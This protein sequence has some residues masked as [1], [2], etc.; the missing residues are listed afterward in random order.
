MV[1]GGTYHD[2]DGFASVI[3]PVFRASGHEIERT[4]DLDALTC[5]GESRVD[6]VVLYTC[7]G[8]TREDDKTGEDLNAVQTKSLV[9]WV[10]EGGGLLAVHAATVVG[11][12]NPE[13]RQL[14]GGA[15]VSHP[16]EFSFTV[17]PMSREHPITKGVEAFS[18]HDELYVET[19]D[20][21]VD[22]HMVALDRGV[23]YPM[24]WSKREGKGRVA[25]IALGHSV[26]VWELAPYQRLML[27][28]V[29]WL[30]SWNTFPAIRDRL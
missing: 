12:S 1:L 2:F 29:N 8:G 17:Y 6:V 18:V 27:Q 7:L 23:C 25:H 11:E 16:P 9:K 28:A 5:I 15:F 10:R 30:A 24:V 22:V 13:L 21:I 26:R 19:Y 20:Q 3:E 14:I 4:Y